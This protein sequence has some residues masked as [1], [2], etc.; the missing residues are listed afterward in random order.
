[1]AGGLL[2]TAV[3]PQIKEFVIGPKGI[4][5]KLIELKKQVDEQQALIEQLVETF[6]SPEVFRHLAGVALLHQYKYWQ[7]D[8]VGELFQREFYFLKIRGFIGP[9]EQ[10][11]YAKMDGENL[12]GKVQLTDI[13]RAYLKMRRDL[14]PSEWLK[15][16]GRNNLDTEV[17]RSLGLNLD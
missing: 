1:M 8:N 4:S 16:A 13:G 14:V 10:E 2:L 9:R 17:A 12:V 3:L 11:F 5:A 15:P 6:I 7:N